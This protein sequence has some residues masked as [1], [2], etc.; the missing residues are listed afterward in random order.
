MTFDRNPRT[1]LSLHRI[2][3]TYPPEAEL[4][5]HREAITRTEDRSPSWTPDPSYFTDEEVVEMLV[6]ARLAYAN[7]RASWA[8]QLYLHA[9]HGTKLWKHNRDDYRYARRMVATLTAAVKARVKA[10]EKA[11][12]LLRA[13]MK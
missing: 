5:A 10:H 1:L 4:D 9:I 6:A 2:G 12:R 3:D 13:A 8:T 11:T 7:A